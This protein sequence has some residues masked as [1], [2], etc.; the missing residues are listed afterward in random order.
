MEQAMNPYELAKFLD[1]NDVKEM[2]RISKPSIYKNLKKLADKGFLSANP[3]KEGE[4]PE[5][6]VYSINKKGREYF[7]KLMEQYAESDIK[8]HFDFNSMLINLDKVSP[9]KGLELIQKME[10]RLITK[11][12]RYKKYIEKYSFLPLEAMM[13]IKQ[14][15][16]LNDTLIRWLEDFR[17]KYKDKY[18]NGK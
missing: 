11:K 6:T 1:N 13:I 10:E 7:L 2:I 17:E 8:Y 3:I 9:E 5:K 12:E 18:M 15:Q 16:M 14:H 4:M